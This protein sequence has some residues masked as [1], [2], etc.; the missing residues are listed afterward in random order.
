MKVKEWQGDVVFLH[1]V[2]PG[3]ADRSY[4]IQVARLAGLPE[5]VVA[6]AREVLTL[7]ESTERENPATR[8]IDDLPLFAVPVKRE[9]A[10]TA[11]GPS[12]SD[13]YLTDLNP[14]DM[15][16]RDALD[17]LYE[18]KRRLSETGKT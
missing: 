16:P 15:T 4:G 2:G 14:D 1:E 10:R 8:L 7:L 17:A 11:R 6:R 5:A 18:L 13:A 12:A 9:P 3:A